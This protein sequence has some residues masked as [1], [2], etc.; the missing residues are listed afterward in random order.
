MKIVCKLESPKIPVVFRCDRHWIKVHPQ[1]E[2]HSVQK[3]WNEIAVLDCNLLNRCCDWK[4]TTT[5]R[6]LPFRLLVIAFTQFPDT[7]VNSFGCDPQI[8]L[9]CSKA[10]FQNFGAIAPLVQ[11][12]FALIYALI[13]VNTYHSSFY[14]Y[15][16]IILILPIVTNETCTS[17]KH[18]SQATYMNILAVENVPI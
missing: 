17:T 9:A 4:F 16:K 1:T 12:F 6:K 8:F 10:F 15:K 7:T 14:I 5:E 18:F 11:K 13:R 2:A 3:L